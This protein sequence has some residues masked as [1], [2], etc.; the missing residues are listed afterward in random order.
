MG[1]LHLVRVHLLLPMRR[2]PQIK[3]PSHVH[4]CLGVGG[5]DKRDNFI[6]CRYVSS[7]R[8]TPPTQGGGEG[9]GVSS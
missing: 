2:S 4:V 1:M 3:R 9:G 6:Y 7:K 8:M 5:G